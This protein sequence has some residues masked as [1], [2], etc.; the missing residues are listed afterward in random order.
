MSVLVLAAIAGGSTA[1]AEPRA[2][3]AGDLDEDLRERIEEAIGEVDD[4]PAN[5]FQARRRARAAAEDAMAV[6]RSEG[7]YG[8]TIEDDIEGEA[9]PT[10]VIRVTPGPRFL[11]S[12]PDVV[13]IDPP[14][15]PDVATDAVAALDLE[16][17]EPGRAADVIA[18]EGRVI[19]RLSELGYPDAVAGDRRVI[20]DHAASTL[21]PTFRIAAGEPVR[22]DGVLLNTLGRTN[23]RWVER[24]APW[25]AGDRYRPD[26]VA[27]LERRLLETGVYDSV[28]V[29]LAPGDQETEDG[30]RPVIVAL[31][32]QPSRVLEAGVG[33]STSE[34]AGVDAVWTW[35]N[36]FGRADTLRYE[37]RLA[38]IDSRLGVSLSLPHWRRAGRTLTLSAFAVDEDT[39]AYDRRAAGASFALQQRF[40]PTSYFSYGVAIEG[41]Q[42]EELDPRFLVDPP[43]PLERNLA[44]LTLQAGANLDYSNDPLD[45]SQGWRLN[46]D[47]QPTAV[48]GDDSLTFLRAVAQVSAYVPLDEEGTS[49]IAGRVRLGSIIGGDES[50]VP[51]DRRF[52]SG[53]GGSVRGFEY[54]GVGPRFPN[55]T[56]V[57]GSSLFETSVEYRRRIRG[58]LGMAVFIDAGSIGDE[59]TPNFSDIRYAAGV[60]VRYHLPFGPIR[61]DIAVPINPR[62]GDA[63]FQVYVSIGQ[64]F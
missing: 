40:A 6:L 57:G 56:P 36:R 54:Q 46:F 50:R 52:Y 62:D 4:P 13:W 55:G 61:A 22:L 21:Q 64:A 44:I 48:T 9:P 16:P 18:S 20:V 29:A 25:S 45:P 47:V 1:W 17:G 11:V 43:V 2:Q 23:P 63:D 37:A 41:G 34:G 8:A 7:Y 24:L 59:P 42:Y 3:V 53:G 31:S 19:A 33:Y 39:R 49:V 27:E 30:L 35:R 51:S 12:D 5:R 58:A 15:E 38:E 26:T 14:P 28:S 60:G 10:P 32:D